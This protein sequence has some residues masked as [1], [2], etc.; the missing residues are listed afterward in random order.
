MI[1]DRQRAGKLAGAANRFKTTDPGPRTP[2]PE[3]Y[4]FAV[5]MTT[6]CSYF[7]PP[8]VANGCHFFTTSF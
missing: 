6:S 3:V 1:D 5:A 4:F 8:S 7:I 2:D